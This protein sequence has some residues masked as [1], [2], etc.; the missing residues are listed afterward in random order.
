M[1]GPC[2]AI[3]FLAGQRRRT[4]MA[5]TDRAPAKDPARAERRTKTELMA[6]ATDDA[7]TNV[8]R[9]EDA[10]RRMAIAY[11]FLP[12]ERINEGALARQ[13]GASRTPVREALNRLLTDGLI[14]FRPGQGF[15]CRTLDAKEIFDL[16]ELR[17]IL[18]TSAVRLACERASDEALAA[19][20]ADYSAH[21]AKAAGKSIEALVEDDERFHLAVAA[22]SGNGELAKRLGKINERIR[23][24]RWIDM[25][26][27]LPYTRGEHEA[28][29]AAL[30]RRDAE[31]CVEV[32]SAHIGKR[33][34][35]I[36]S[37]VRRG[38][39]RLYVPDIPDIPTSGTDETGR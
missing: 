1:I 39:S 8:G 28:L 25:D 10:V 29:V 23:F 27:R 2:Q 3:L 30:S 11:E 22:L 5:A 4:R 19:V 32:L 33:L 7:T 6:K 16:Y 35:Q 26:D 37:V 12:G 24:A 17:L 9:I 36:V 20:V 15:F 18:E 38:I 14:Q 21:G 34:D 13:L 31:A